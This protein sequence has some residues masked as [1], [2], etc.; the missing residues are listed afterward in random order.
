MGLCHPV[1]Q[2]LSARHCMRHTKVENLT[3]STSLL[4]FTN[5]MTLND[6]T[7]RIPPTLLMRDLELYLAQ[8]RRESEELHEP[9]EFHHNNDSSGSHEICKPETLRY[10]RH[11]NEENFVDD[12]EESVEFVGSSSIE[13][14]GFSWNPRTQWMHQLN[15]CRL[16]Y[17]VS[18]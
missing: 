2:T 10:V 16:Q 18:H 7:Q 17:N 5:P 6:A 11:S 4:N 9:F 3:N 8:Q 15:L 1:C 14:A 12:F 13:F